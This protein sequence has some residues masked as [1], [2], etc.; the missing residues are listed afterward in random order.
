ME[1]NAPPFDWEENAPSSDKPEGQI[2]IYVD[3][4]GDLFHAGHIN[5]LKR[6]SKIG[7]YL[8]VGLVGDE[9]C[10][11]YKREPILTLTERAHVIGNCKYVDAVIPNV[12][13]VLTEE[14][15]NTQ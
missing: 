4:V 13:L 1:S 8:I 12:P 6:A 9:A 3:M 5:M 11:S 15:I 10:K 2:R 14:F 7:N